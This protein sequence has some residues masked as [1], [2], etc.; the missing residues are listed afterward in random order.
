MDEND[1]VGK[2]R[3]ILAMIALIMI[4]VALIAFFREYISHRTPNYITVILSV[5]TIL[6][7]LYYLL[8]IIRRPRNMFLESQKVSSIIR[9]TNCDYVTARE[10]NKGDF[11]LKEV[12]IC[13]RCGNNLVIYSIFREVKEK[14]RRSE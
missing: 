2:V 8:Q 5:S 9:C 4:I 6:L 11:V 14:E 10:F 12:G 13:P 1:K 7:S 3:I